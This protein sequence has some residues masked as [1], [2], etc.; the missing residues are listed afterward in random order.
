LFL[1]SKETVYLHHP[2]ANIICKKGVD[3]SKKKLKADLVGTGW[4]TA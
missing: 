4:P 3:T 1:K 2:S